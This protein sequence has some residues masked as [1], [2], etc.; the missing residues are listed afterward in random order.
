LL[1]SVTPLI[2]LLAFETIISTRFI[3]PEER[4]LECRYGDAYRRYKST[5]RRWI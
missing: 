1:G 5:V 3:D 4:A 2:V